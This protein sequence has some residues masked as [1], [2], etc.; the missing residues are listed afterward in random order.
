MLRC[1]VRA[2]AG[3]A[4]VVEFRSLPSRDS[5]DGAV[6]IDLRGYWQLRPLNT[7]ETEV[8]LMVDA[9]PKTSLP[10]FLVDPELRSVVIQTLRALT[11]RVTQ[12]SH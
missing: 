5:I 12:P 10:D 9:D 2:A 11:T 4:L 7:E 1:L 6:R 3:G 8:T